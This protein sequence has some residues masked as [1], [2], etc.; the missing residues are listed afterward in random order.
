MGRSDRALRYI[1]SDS[2]KEGG[3]KDDALV[4]LLSD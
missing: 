1:G 4:F 2:G 3:V